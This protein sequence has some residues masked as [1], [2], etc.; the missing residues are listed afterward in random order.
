MID[1]PGKSPHNQ[2]S[3]M[4]KFL[5]NSF[6]DSIKDVDSVGLDKVGI[7]LSAVCLIHCL[8]TPLLML[9][10]PILARYYLAHPWFH[11]GLALLII[12]VGLVAFYSGYKHHHNNLVWLLGVPGLVIIALVPYLV[13]QLLLPI[14][15]ALVMTFGSVMVL[16]A[17]W[18]NKK[19][20]QKCCD[21][22]H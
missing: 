16:A 21:H 10:L 5:E 4:N 15:E 6:K 12:P 7:F 17:H 8:L 3:S 9:S 14:P 13:H 1:D 2:S 22:Q 19:N 18:I 11:I 20:C